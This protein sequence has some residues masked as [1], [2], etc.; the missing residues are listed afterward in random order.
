MDKETHLREQRAKLIALSLRFTNLLVERRSVIEL[1][2]L[3]AVISSTFIELKATEEDIEQSV[4]PS[5]LGLT[6]DPAN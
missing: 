1:A 3:F 4:S 5:D 2:P 6:T